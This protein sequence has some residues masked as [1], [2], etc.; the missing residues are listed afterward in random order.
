VAAQSSLRQGALLVAPNAVDSY[1]SGREYRE[2]HAPDN[3]VQKA[4]DG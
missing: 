1:G 2:P 3:G 4:R